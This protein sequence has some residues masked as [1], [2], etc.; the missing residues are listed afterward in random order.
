MTIYRSVLIFG[1]LYLM[2]FA[3]A[4]QKYT[5]ADTLKGTYS[6]ERAW[7]D[8]LHYDLSVRFFPNDSSISGK[9]R[10]TYKVLQQPAEMQIDLLS[11]MKLD[12]V[13]QNGRSCKVRTDGDAY[14]VTVDGATQI[15]SIGAL[16]IYFHGKPRIAK[17]APWD[18]GIIWTKDK[19]GKP[20]ISS[21]CQ[22]MAAR[23][24]FPNKDHQADE[25]DSVS[26]HF[27][28]PRDLVAVS[29]GVM[30][31]LTLEEPAL[32][33]YH[34]AVKNPINNYNIIPYI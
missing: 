22:G 1:C 15:N 16:D 17:N 33:T 21:A 8:V 3:N 12:S 23:V 19:K 32:S 27:T 30:T 28:V 2:A 9:N 20:W 14:F 11:P 24:W 31:N 26:L 29:N 5:H 25:P 10:M 4:Q 13:I 18:G 34:W 6:K 7:W